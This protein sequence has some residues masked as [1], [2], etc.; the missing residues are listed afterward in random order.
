MKKRLILLAGLGAGYVLGSRAGRQSYEKLKA[1]VQEWWG[2]PRVQETVS[3]VTETVKEKA[4]EV[5]E[6]VKEKAPIV[7]DTVKE[8]TSQ[9]ASTVKDKTAQATSS[10]KSTADTPAPPVTVT[11]PAS[12][13]TT[14][15]AAGGPKKASATNPA[16]S[17]VRDSYSDP[18][19]DPISE[20]P[21]HDRD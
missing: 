9:A 19:T 2:D 17:A 7:A 11:E 15:S 8:K 13:A 10:S 12:P 1:Q 5:A 16:P 20:G 18:E 3:S 6:A 4:P 21:S 14:S